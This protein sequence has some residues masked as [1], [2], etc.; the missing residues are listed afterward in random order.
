LR[1]GNLL[2]DACNAHALLHWRN[3]RPAAQPAFLFEK[4]LF[5]KFLRRC[6]SPRIHKTKFMEPPLLRNITHFLSLSPRAMQTREEI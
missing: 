5:E 1:Q 4:F 6:G 2:N 3:E